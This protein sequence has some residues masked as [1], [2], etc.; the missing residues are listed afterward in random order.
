MAENRVDL[1]GGTIYGREVYTGFSPPGG[2][3]RL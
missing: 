3:F 2:L 1:N